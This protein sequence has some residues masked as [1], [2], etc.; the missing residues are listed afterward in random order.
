MLQVNGGEIRVNSIKILYAIKQTSIP[1]FEDDRRI[2]H[3][4]LLGLYSYS[5]SLRYDTSSLFSLSYV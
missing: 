3:T 2:S 5:S 1:S 4:L